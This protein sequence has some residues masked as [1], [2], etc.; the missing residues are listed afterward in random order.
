MQIAFANNEESAARIGSVSRSGRGG[1]CMSCKIQANVPGIESPE[2][3]L[4]RD[5]SYKQNKKS[6]PV[7][8]EAAIG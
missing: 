6:R 3:A 5:F 2:S 8:S 4:R 7:T 1:F